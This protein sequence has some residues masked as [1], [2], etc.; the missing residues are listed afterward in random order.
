M[1]AFYRSLSYLLYPGSMSLL[2]LAFIHALYPVNLYV[3]MVFAFGMVI[4]PLVALALFIRMGKVS[5]IFIYHREQRHG[6]YALGVVFAS[7]ATG[8]IFW[9]AA[10]PAMIWSACN[11]VV[12]L[13]LFVIN[14]WGVKASA[15]MA[16]V[17]GLL[18]WVLFFQCNDLSLLSVILLVV[19]VYAA[20]RGLSAHSH[21]ELILGFCL[22]LFVT[23]ALAYLLLN[24][25]GISCSFV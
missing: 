10:L 5:D 11:T 4:L 24:H 21:F 9:E 23:F 25:Y 22:G 16:G 12:L 7:L 18:G 15:H 20:R 13:L 14:Y 6:L 19:A 8:F 1:L 17:S 3:W 2:G